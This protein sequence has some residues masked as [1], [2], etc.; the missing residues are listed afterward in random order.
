MLFK[1]II[2]GVIVYGIY[3]FFG[4]EVKFPS[5]NNKEKKEELE[6]E[7]TMVECKSC[8]TYVSKKE[9]LKYKD[10]YYCSKECIPD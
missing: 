7:N 6:E 3:K 1:L 5:F 8:G 9:A 4:G 10:N 2:L